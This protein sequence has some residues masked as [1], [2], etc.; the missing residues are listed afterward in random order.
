MKDLRRNK[1]WYPDLIQN[2]NTDQQKEDGKDLPIHG[3]EL[4]S[5]PEG[6]DCTVFIPGHK[7]S[8]N[9]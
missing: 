4:I 1:G 5:G 8:I 3:D 2:K 7:H 6:I 9:R